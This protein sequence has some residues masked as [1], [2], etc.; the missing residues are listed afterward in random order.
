LALPISR[1]IDLHRALAA[2][3]VVAERVA[4]AA[5]LEEGAYFTHQRGAIREA[6]AAHGIAGR[7][8]TLVSHLLD[9]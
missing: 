8:D 4:A 7:I 3:A 2:A 6:L 9:H 1:R 5:E